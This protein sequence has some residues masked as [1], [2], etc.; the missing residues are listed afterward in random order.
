MKWIAHC[1]VIP[2]EE[3]CHR[4]SHFSLIPCCTGRNNLLFLSLEHN[5]LVGELPAAEG[6]LQ[7]NKA[8]MKGVGGVA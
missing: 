6:A 4:A 5:S 7:L 1:A 8:Y 3:E 2:C